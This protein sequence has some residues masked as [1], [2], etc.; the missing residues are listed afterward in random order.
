MSARNRNGTCRN[1]IL[2]CSGIQK[3]S[4]AVIIAE[5]Y[6]ELFGEE[7]EARMD[8]LETGRGFNMEDIQKL[9]GM[10]VNELLQELRAREA[11]TGETAMAVPAEPSESLREFNDATIVR[12]LKERQKVIYETDDRIDVCDLPSGPNRDDVQSV[13]QFAEDKLYKW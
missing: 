4:H 7:F 2:I 12:V 5:I 3:A 8:H 13:W 10:P 1:K 9:R 6:F 11:K